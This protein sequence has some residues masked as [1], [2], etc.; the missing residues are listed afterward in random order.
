MQQAS[1]RQLLIAAILIGTNA[2]VQAQDLDQGQT[3]FLSKCAE[4]H[5]ADG[6]GAGP[7][8]SKPKSKPAD[9]TTLA[10]RNNGVFSPDA[11]AATVDGRSAIG[12]RAVDMPIWGCRQGPPPGPQSK[13]YEPKPI[14]S[15]LDM[16]CD[17]EEVIRKRILEI[18]D[19]LGRIQEK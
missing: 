10:R 5:G 9:L 17:P 12:H 8:S 13:A 2:S 3:E 6:K 19:Y 11:I 14:D 4:C 15:L 18:V 16:P 1:L 7:M